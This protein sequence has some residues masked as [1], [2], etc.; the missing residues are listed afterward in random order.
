[1]NL[2]DA[3]SGGRREMLALLAGLV[4][5]AVVF[6][7]LRP[8]E[9]RSLRVVWIEIALAAAAH[10]AAGIADASDAFRQ[11]M[12]GAA[13][14]LAGLA[15]IQLAALCFF[16]G[17]LPLVRLNAPRIAQDL[18]VIGLS[19][20]WCL[21][22]LRL[23]GV[24][25][26][27]VL[28]TSALI[29][30]V[31]AFSMQDT[32]GNVLG[33]VALQLDNSLRVGDWVRV[34]DVSGRV[35][36]VRW[37]YTAIE[38]RGRELVVVPNSWLMKNRFTVI[39]K[40]AEGPL[41]WRRALNFNV[42][43]E[44]APHAVRAALEH[45][46]VDAEIDHVLREPPPSAIL[47]DVLPGYHR[48]TLRY[49]LADPQ[50]DDPTDSAVRMHALAALAR[51][52]IRPGM[53][54]E[55]RLTVKENETFHAAAEKR[56][57]ARR[58]HAI[59]N[60]ELFAG[61]GEAEQAQLAEHLVHAPFAPGDVMTRQGAVAHWLYLITAGEARVV[62]ESAQGPVA[63]GNLRGG[64]VFG[65]LG[66]LTGEPRRATVIAQT[67]VECYRLDKEGFAQLLQ[68]RPEVATVVAAIA[69]KRLA[70]T[71]NRVA[72][73]DAAAQHEDLLT[74]ILSFFSL[75]PA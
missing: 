68:A 28:T 48:Y 67:A 6:R 56:E 69:E 32:L 72:A 11:A 1:M 59:R 51:A 75:T 50:F 43:H 54:V 21:V 8:A 4:V 13:L 12:A 60:T 29:T 23:A 2:L 46:V 70:Q 31:V 53:P 65:E 10:V 74:R 27:Q 58:L 7:L 38:T 16:R 47:A 61:L 66:M 36:D 3:A 63:V 52:G 39:R 73:A 17:L 15:A 5:V 71:G 30:A 34:D 49:W 44:A 45:A 20:A 55:E 24:D 57:L 18:S 62:V 25:P 33:G 19:I 22:W 42:D 9:R 64:D 37:R 26:S 35:A 14:M 41:A 40:P